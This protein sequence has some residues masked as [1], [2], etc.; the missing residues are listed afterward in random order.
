MTLLTGFGGKLPLAVF[1]IWL[2]WRIVLA[3]L[4]T[5]HQRLGDGRGPGRLRDAQV[6]FLATG[7]PP[8]PG[9]SAVRPPEDAGE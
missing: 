3:S 7:S 6:L 9:A 8:S 1:F 5:Y 4:A 2:Y